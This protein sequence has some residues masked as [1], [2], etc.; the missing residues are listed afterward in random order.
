LPFPNLETEDFAPS[1][2]RAV[3]RGHATRIA[4]R[5]LG[6]RAIFP[7]GQLAGLGELIVPLVTAGAMRR[8]AP[9]YRRQFAVRRV[10]RAN[11]RF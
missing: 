7:G 1:G 9:A 8:P 10:G 3:S 6:R 11:G 2:R 5:E 4:L